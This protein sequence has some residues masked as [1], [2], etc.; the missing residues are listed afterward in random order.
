MRKT[1][2]YPIS[3]FLFML[4]LFL[5]PSVSQAMS[6]TSFEQGD[7][8]IN[9]KNIEIHV[10]NGENEAEILIEIDGEE[11]YINS[12]PLSMLDQFAIYENYFIYTSRVKGSANALVYEVLKVDNGEISVLYRSEPIERAKYSFENN[13]LHLSFPKYTGS[14]AKT[15][16][17]YIVTEIYEIVNGNW[18][19]T[20]EKTEPFA[21]KFSKVKI[22]LL[23]QKNP[24]FSEI[25]D[26]LTEEAL[27]ANVSPEI[28]KAI[29][30]Q[31]SSWEQY[32]NT[33]PESIKQCKDG[34]RTIAYDGTNVKLGYDCIGI[35]IM[36]ISDHMYWEP[37]P[38]KDAY[39]ERLKRDIRFNIQEGIRILKEKWNYHRSG[40][41]P[42][43]NDNDPMVI[44]NWYFA[45]LAYN[46]LLPRNN[47][48]S[49]AYNAYQ[50]VV[51]E[52]LRDYS[53]VDITP[54][55]TFKL[56][57]Y[58]LNN[59][60]LRF[61]NDN[62]T[63]EGPKHY[64]SQSLKKGDTSYVTAN[65]LRLRKT[66]GGEIIGSLN[67]GTKVTI[68]GD[69]VGNNSRVSQFVWFPIK[70]SSG[71]TGYVASSYLS[72]KN[73]YIDTYNLFGTNRYETS[74][75]IS[76]HGWHWNQPESVIIGRGDL[77]IDALTGSV[78]AATLDAPLLL[79]RSTYLV[80]IVEKEID[81]LK[82]KNIYILGGEQAISKEV[83]NKLA[84]KASGNVIRISATKGSRYDTAY[85]VAKQVA[86]FTNVD[87]I[88]ITTGSEKSSDALAI[89]PYAGAE[90][91]PILFTRSN[92]LHENIIRF[93]QEH[94]IKKATII[95]GTTAVSKNA[96]NTL[97]K[98]VSNVER[99]SG[100]TRFSTNTAIIE[101]YYGEGTSRHINNSRVFVAQGLEIADA[102]SV[103][104][105]A[106]KLNSPLLLT[107]SYNV[108]IETSTW[109][110]NHIKAKPNV[111]FIG[112]RVAI[113]EQVR[114]NIINLVR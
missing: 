37:G 39:I 82:P 71:Q 86:S 99:V 108:P 49:N 106:A 88:F 75:A 109:M 51:F 103:S 62:V 19:K 16:P 80:D 66:P 58:T 29:A 7:N 20:S 84:E 38:E 92:T 95:G 100:D 15:N 107:R 55:P 104:S 27:K 70:T 74:V 69:Y 4:I 31:E 40:L 21:S 23:S 97:K 33:V 77:P 13:Q 87:E 26:M 52:R 9:D 12:F 36:Q 105:L 54:F 81:R 78:L 64:S 44:E 14:E 10:Y 96:E 114:E 101:K 46:G 35:G 60:Q 17:T 24:S 68:T 113:S 76:N 72:P 73:E 47:P 6:I 3:T 28:V 83:E 2:L 34:D 42:T 48:L 59:G 1:L 91:I 79:T 18:K 8:Y 89:A 85:E 25:N 112:G 111:Y 43:V 56:E 53:L 30:F 57:P 98:Y 5:S 102:L 63:T 93:I 45:I 11:K 50:E 90:G 22:K 65:S 67:K 41:I 32:W 94:N 110:K 61:K